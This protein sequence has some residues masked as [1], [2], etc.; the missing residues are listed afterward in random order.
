MLP[1]DPSD[2]AQSKANL[3]KAPVRSRSRSSLGRGA[4]KSASPGSP[5]AAQDGELPSQTSSA[6]PETLPADAEVPSVAGC[7]SPPHGEVLSVADCESPVQ[8]CA[9][10]P[11]PPSEAA[12]A[13]P[14]VGVCSQYVPAPARNL[15]DDYLDHYYS[16]SHRGSPKRRMEW[17]PATPLTAKS[18]KNVKVKSPPVSI[19]Q[20]VPIE[21]SPVRPNVFPP[22]YSA[23]APVP[24]WA[25]IPPQ[26]GAEGNK[27]AQGVSRP[28][29][30]VSKAVLKKPLL[31]RA[32]HLIADVD[33]ESD[34]C[35]GTH[36]RIPGHRTLKSLPMKVF[37]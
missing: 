34:V 5:E 36:S 8:G 31:E 1:Q 15:V 17:S 9:P 33:V 28:G 24:P 30:E 12:C 4:G 35:G 19:A 26:Q 32:K 10:C 18:H 23:Q 22:A 6:P 20:S 2:K 7:A 29:Q 21:E 3:E 16:V 27:E 37:V 11:S 25:V 14:P 13:V